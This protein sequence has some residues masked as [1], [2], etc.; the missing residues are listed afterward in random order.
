MSRTAAELRAAAVATGYFNGPTLSYVGDGYTIPYQ[1]ATAAGLVSA[2]LVM[3]AFKLYLDTFH[4]EYSRLHDWLYTP[5]GS[6]IGASQSEADE[7]LRDEL[8]VVDPVSAQIV[9]QACAA[10]GHLYFGVSQVGYVGGGTLPPPNMPI[11]SPGNLLGV[12]TMP[13]K[14]VI[15]FQQTSTP[16]IDSPALNY[17]AV[18]RTGGWSE[19]LYGPDA[20]S[21][22]IQML[23]GPRPAPVTGGLLPGRAACL[24]NQASIIGVRL[25]AGGSGKGQLLSVSYRGSAGESDIPNIGVLC[26]AFDGGSGHSRRWLVRGV[27][28]GQIV[29]AEFAPDP[30]FRAR[31]QNYFVALQGFSWKYATFGLPKKIV[32]IAATG[33]CSTDGAHAYPIN[34]WVTVKQTTIKATGQRVGGRFK[35][36][37]PITEDTFVLSGWPHGAC[38]SGNVGIAGEGTA[39]IDATTTISAVRAAERKVG[40]P[41]VKYVG[42]KSNARPA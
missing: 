8:A 7:A 32:E 34:T 9:Y 15:L 19:S 29:N 30:S 11:G 27:P 2:G 41:F 26:S 3:A 4:M 39:T 35:V 40:R 6:L 20:T 23:K 24:S 36:V 18:Q 14:I 16:T 5:Y 1:T 42:R 12:P 17:T 22:V 28:D 25:Y 37:A 31:L 13:T 38:K 21:Q 33:V 10:F